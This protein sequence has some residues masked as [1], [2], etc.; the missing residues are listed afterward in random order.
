MMRPSVFFIL[1]CAAKRTLA[2]CSESSTESST[3]TS[4]ATPSGDEEPVETDYPLDDDPGWFPG[5]V[6][7]FSEPTNLVPLVII[8]LPFFID[9][10]NTTKKAAA[11]ANATVSCFIPLKITFCRTTSHTSQVLGVTIAVIYYHNT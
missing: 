11:K 4:L 1:L 2:T 3:T 7:F 8:A 6:D 5:I 9:W 10:S